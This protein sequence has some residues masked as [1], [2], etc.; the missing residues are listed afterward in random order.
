MIGADVKPADVVAHNEEDVRRS[1]GRR[2][3]LLRLRGGC[4]TS[5]RQ[6]RRRQQRTAAQQQIAPFQSL[7]ILCD[8]IFQ[9]F[10]D[11]VLTHNALLFLLMH[12][13]PTWLVEVSTG[14]AWRAAGR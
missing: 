14:S 11:L 9:L 13:K 10:A 7:A 6:H 4:Q 2:R 8:A 1:A 5:I 3:L 12:L